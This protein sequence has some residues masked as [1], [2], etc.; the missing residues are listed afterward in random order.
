MFRDVARLSWRLTGVADESVRHSWFVRGDTILQILSR[1]QKV[2]EIG[3]RTSVSGVWRSLYST[4]DSEQHEV[5]PPRSR[6]NDNRHTEF[7]SIYADV[8]SKNVVQQYV[9]SY[10]NLC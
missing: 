6:V 5:I 4:I 3:Q 8:K 10:V 7:V 1:T 9:V 2:S